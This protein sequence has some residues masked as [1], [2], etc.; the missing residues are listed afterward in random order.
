MTFDHIIQA[1][2]TDSI[3]NDDSEKKVALQS[4]TL[5]NQTNA[6]SYAESQ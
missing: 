5:G 3:S 6:M 2:T 4:N 1:N